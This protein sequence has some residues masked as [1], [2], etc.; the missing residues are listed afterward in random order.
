MVNLLGLFC[1]LNCYG[2][3]SLLVGKVDLWVE[4]AVAGLAFVLDIGGLELRD[5]GAKALFYLGQKRIV[6]VQISAVIWVNQVCSHSYHFSAVCPVA[7]P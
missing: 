6:L 4:T 1:R 5:I 7:T 3:Q 2:V